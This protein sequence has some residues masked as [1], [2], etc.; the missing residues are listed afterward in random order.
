GHWES[1]G[2]KKEAVE[3]C[4]LM[5]SCFRSFDCSSSISCISAVPGVKID[6]PQFISSREGSAFVTLKCEQD[7]RQ[8]YYMYWY[9]Q[10]SSGKL[11]LLTYSTGQD[12][13]NTQTPIEKSKYTM[14]RP[15]VLNSTLHIYPVKPEDTALYYCASS[16]TQWFRK[17]EQLN[18][19]LSGEKNHYMMGR[20]DK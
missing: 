9:K 12:D 4:G 5:T 6:Q 13:S 1:V 2:V 3:N 18:N 19:N 7:D 11:E 15:S 10:S 8:Y 14:S 17:P 20:I 16:R